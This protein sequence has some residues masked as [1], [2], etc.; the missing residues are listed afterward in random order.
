MHIC[1]DE[2]AAALAAVPV[3]TLIWRRLCCWMSTHHTKSHNC[4]ESEHE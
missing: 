3:V 2:I 1:A 4:E